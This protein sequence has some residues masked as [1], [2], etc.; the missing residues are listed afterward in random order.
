MQKQRKNAKEAQTSTGRSAKLNEQCQ[1]WSRAK[2]K[3]IH[4]H[5]ELTETVSDRSIDVENV[6]PVSSTNKTKS[7]FNHSPPS[8]NVTRHSQLKSIFDQLQPG[9]KLIN[10]T[11]SNK[12]EDDTN[13]L[14]KSYA[15]KLKTMTKRRQATVKF[16]IAKLMLKAELEECDEMRSLDNR[17]ILDNNM[18]TIIEH[19]VESAGTDAGDTFIK[20]SPSPVFDNVDPFSTSPPNPS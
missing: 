13:L 17:V 18:V 9:D 10:L 19:P 15:I 12:D 3:S 16:E 5:L 6:H 4:P 1:L 8:R 14:F 20:S 2:L 11:D 7:E